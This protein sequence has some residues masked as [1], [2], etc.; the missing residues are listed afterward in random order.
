MTRATRKV[1]WALLDVEECYGLEV[2][3]RTRLAGGTVPRR[4]PLWDTPN[5]SLR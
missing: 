3:H 5:A 1:L 2:V 4:V